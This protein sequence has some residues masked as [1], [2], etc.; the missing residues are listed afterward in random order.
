[1]ALMYVCREGM[2][3]VASELIKTGHV[4]P[5]QFNDCDSTVLI[6][7]CWHEMYKVAWELMKT[8]HGNLYDMNKGSYTGTIFCISKME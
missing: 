8:G 5:E 2:I 7:A 3:K 4:K 6:Y 1:M